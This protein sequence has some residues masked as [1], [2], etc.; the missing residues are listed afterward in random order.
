MVL[1]ERIGKLGKDW[2][3]GKRNDLQEHKI[4]INYKKIQFN[5]KE[6]QDLSLL[7]EC[8]EV[9]EAFEKADLLLALNPLESLL[10]LDFVIL[11]SSSYSSTNLLPSPSLSVSFATI[12][13]LKTLL[14]TNSS[15]GSFL[16]KMF[17]LS[18]KSSP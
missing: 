2:K 12:S 16:T 1:I 3:I 5:Q 13:A 10:L 14:S 4:D 15:S 17:C 8:L 18:S 7:L 9:L 11:P 6:N